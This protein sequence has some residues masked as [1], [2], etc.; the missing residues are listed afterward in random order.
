MSIGSL[1]YFLK[2]EGQ[3]PDNVLYQARLNYGAFFIE[4][5]RLTCVVLN[6]D[7]VDEVLGHATNHSH[8]H[9][10][11]NFSKNYRFILI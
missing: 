7:Q 9:E 3:F 8:Q 5:D 4:K 2:N 6:P 11:R 1:G 10:K